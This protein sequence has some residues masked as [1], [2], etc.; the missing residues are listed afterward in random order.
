MDVLHT[1]LEVTDLDETRRFYEDL[2]G[3]ERSREYEKDGVRNYYVT[4]SGPA[5]L[6]FRV[7]DEVPSPAGIEHV[8]VAATDVD[9]TVEEAAAEWGDVVEREPATLERVNRRLA[10]LTDPDGYS[11][12]VIEE[13]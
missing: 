2:L 3:L 9:A 11:V 10:V 13:L 12:H 7:V 6:Q 4:G 1:A 5:E 8:A